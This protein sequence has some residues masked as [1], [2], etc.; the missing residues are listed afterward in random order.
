MCDNLFTK[1]AESAI[2]RNPRGN[3]TNGCV[4][5]LSSVAKE[6]REREKERINFI[7][8]KSITFANEFA[9]ILSTIELTS[10]LLA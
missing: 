6:E 2:E 9:T 8:N 7:K 10:A 5:R 4:V 3:V 1:I